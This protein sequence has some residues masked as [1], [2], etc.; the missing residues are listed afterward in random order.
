LAEVAKLG[1]EV[2]GASLL[3]AEILEREPNITGSGIAGHHGLYKVGGDGARDPG[4]DDAI[5]AAPIREARCR[6]VSSREYLPTTRS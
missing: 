4:L 2:E 6:C 1:V 3:I 5:H